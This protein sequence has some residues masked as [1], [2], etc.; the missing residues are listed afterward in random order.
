MKT[1]DKLLTLIADYNVT[2]TARTLYQEYYINGLTIKECIS[3]YDNINKY[4]IKQFINLRS[5]I[6][7]ILIGALTGYFDDVDDRDNLKK[8]ILRTIDLSYTY[9]NSVLRISASHQKI[10]KI[11]NDWFELNL[12]LQEIPQYIGFIS[13]MK[14]HHACFHIDDHIFDD[15]KSKFNSNICYN[16]YVHKLHKWINSGLIT[17]IKNNRYLLTHFLVCKNMIKKY[18][19]NLINVCSREER[20]ILINKILYGIEMRMVFFYINTAPTVD[21]ITSTFTDLPDIIS[22][23]KNIVYNPDIREF[24]KYKLKQY[25][26]P[27]S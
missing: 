21:D 26:R 23:V 16:E 8:L 18:L 5:H 22:E 19:F 20:D 12:P 25:W 15:Y 6:P 4:T 17:H 9:K 24:L 27:A 13:L 10:T 1:L 14:V 3:K 11:F 7:K 2:A